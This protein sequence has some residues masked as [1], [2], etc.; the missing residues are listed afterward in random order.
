MLLAS[1]VTEEELVDIIRELCDDILARVRAMTRP[2]APWVMEKTP[3]Y[4]TPARAAIEWKLRCY[5][6][7]WY[8]HIVRDEAAVARSIVTG[9]HYGER[10]ARRAALRGGQAA[11]AVRDVLSG[12]DRARELHYEDLRADPAGQVAGIIRWLG[13]E[14]D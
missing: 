6:D 4:G 7:A 14:A 2:Q 12:H 13:L 10:S 3:L 9:G 5:P 1:F 11:T 8:L